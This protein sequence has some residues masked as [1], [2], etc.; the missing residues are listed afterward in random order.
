MMVSPVSYHLRLTSFKI[1]NDVTFGTVFN[2]MDTFCS[3]SPKCKGCRPS[4]PSKINLLKVGQ[5]IGP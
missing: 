4:E 1:L 3:P 2:Y 5:R